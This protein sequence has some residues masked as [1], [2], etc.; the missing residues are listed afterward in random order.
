MKT[1]KT[2][3][4]A[5]LTLSALGVAQAAAVTN[6][7]YV[8]T[9]GTLVS[10]SASSDYVTGVMQYLDASGKSFEAFCVE[11]ALGH[12]SS[13][14]GFQ[15]YSIGS[16]GGSQASLLQGLFSSSYASLSSAE[17]KA[18]FQV[19]VWE[20]THETSG[21]MDAGSGSFSFYWLRDDST[22]AED[23][24]FLSLT[25]G[26]LSAASSYSG[27]SRYSIVKLSN[28]SYQDLLVAS[29][30]PEPQTYALMLAGLGAIVFTARRRKPR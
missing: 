23:S 25:S 6:I 17:Q 18:A 10:T 1:S 4:A 14:A 19:A 30:V 16:F 9:S 11:L 15:P 24:A 2:L 8:G 12:A 27:P 7:Q 3:L 28:A 20:I 26:Y 21:V 22:A 13:S 5:A 29:A